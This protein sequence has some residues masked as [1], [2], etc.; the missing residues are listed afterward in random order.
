MKTSCRSLWTGRVMTS[1]KKSKPDW[2]LEIWRKLQENPKRKG[3]L[4]EL[5]SRKLAYKKSVHERL[6]DTYSPSITKSGPSRASTRDPSHSR[7]RSLCRNRLQ[8]R[9]R[10][11]GIKESYDD[12]YSS[13]GTGTKYRDRSHDRY[14]SRS[15]KRW[16]ESESPPSRGSESST[17][18][19]RHWKSKAKRHKP[20][21]EED[22]VVPWTC[23]DVDPFTP[24]IRK[25]KSSRKTR[26]PNNVKTYDG[27]E[28]PEDHLKIFQ[29]AAQQKKYVKDPVEIHNIKQRDGET[30]E[31]FMEH[32]KI[33]TGR[34]KGAPKCMRISGF[35]HGVNNPELTKRL[36]EHVPKTME[37]M[38]TATTTFIQGETA[39]ASKKKVHTTWKS[40]DQPKRHTSERRPDFRNQPKDGRGS[41][42]FNPLTRTPKENF[43]AESGKF[44]PPPPMVTPVEKRSSN[45]FGEFHN[46]KGHITN[47]CV[48]LR[49]QIK[50]L[51]WQRMMRQKVT[52]SFARVKEITF[53]PL[54]ANK[55]TEGPLV[56][57]AKIGGHAVHRMRRRAFYE[58]M[59]EFYDSDVTITVQRIVT[60]RSTILTPT[61]CT[62]IAATPKDSAKKAEAR[63][64]KF[65]VAIHPHFPN[66]EITIGRTVSTKAR[67]KLCTLLKGNLDIFAWHPS[68]MT[69]VPRSIT[70][71]RL[72]IREG[73]PLVRQKKRG[74]APERT[75][76]IQ[77]EVQKLVEAGILREVYYHDWLSN[78]V[79][80][81]KHD[82]SWRMCVD[83]TNLN[84]ACPQDCYP[85]LEIDWK[86]E[87]LYGYPFKCLLDSYKGYHQIQ[88]AEQDKE[89]T[90]I[91]TSHGVYCYTKIPFGLKNA[92][93]TYQRLVD[94]A[95]DKQIGRNLEI[96]VDDLVIKSHTET[97][98]LRD[99]E[100]TFRTLRKI[101]MKL[102]PKKCTF[103]AAEGMF[104][105][106]MIS[107]EGIKPC[108]DKTEAVLQLPSLRTIKEV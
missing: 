53:P 71:H 65:K 31:E 84:K 66:Q 41:N 61:E 11:R 4:P 98:L 60:I 67:T 34:M 80:V 15:I 97:E 44:K 48:Q 79:M 83:F 94:K 37:E 50:E 21:N 59:D 77:V 95:F 5:K 107:P 81:K 70:E 85:L 18:N 96:Y 76:A 27:A 75:K 40:Q 100:E 3:E 82:A 64:E 54:T 45:K 35:M 88:M 22:L 55:E 92:G 78:P 42:K 91:H 19:R 36:N 29:A 20:T 39:A 30:I 69:G 8:I 16:R 86:I 58:S 14:H 99:I 56:I 89:K 9:D 46:D 47:E 23:E 38:M 7:G 108:P 43:A 24:R 57:E 90:A 68:D 32:F 26:M 12:A 33:E 49:K 104:L 10:L 25:F 1:E 63:Y 2:I 106:Y 52:Q 103:G 87:S 101:N 6:S 13:Y 17:S 74:Q 105:G 72:N 28:D 73:Y 93:A 51:P 102:N 62:T